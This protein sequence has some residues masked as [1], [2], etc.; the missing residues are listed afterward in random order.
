LQQLTATTSTNDFD[1]KTAG[2]LTSQIEVARVR[3][4]LLSNLRVDT[5]ELIKIY[6]NDG[7]QEFSEN[8]SEAAFII[9]DPNKKVFYLGVDAFAI[10][11]LFYA[12]TQDS[13]LIDSDLKSIVGRVKEGLLI[14]NH[15]L[16]SYFN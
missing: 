12:K 3:L 7:I 10:K 8:I 1:C 5:A 4:F 15:K 6:Q 13:L 9:N 14:N 11:P 16:S 2:R